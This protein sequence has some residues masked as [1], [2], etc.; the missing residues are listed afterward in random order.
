MTVRESI[1]W[2][3]A[4]VLA[5]LFLSSLTINITQWW[6]YKKRQTSV[7]TPAY[8][9]EGNPCY[10]AAKVNQSGTADTNVQDAHVYDVVQGQRSNK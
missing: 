6:I 10:E 9:M 5:V 8:E 7:K 2:T 1:A 4:A 3:L